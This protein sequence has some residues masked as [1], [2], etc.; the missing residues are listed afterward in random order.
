MEMLAIIC[1]PVNCGI[2]VFTGDGSFNHP[3][4]SSLSKFLV[5]V[6][7]ELWDARTILLLAIL[8][9]HLLL[10]IKAIMANMI[11]DV[12]YSVRKYLMKL[13]KMEKKAAALI[14]E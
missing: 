4:E 14:M 9:E 12:P 3:G 10:M 7:D 6:D 1:I 2:V 11:A 8:L 5:G 13:P